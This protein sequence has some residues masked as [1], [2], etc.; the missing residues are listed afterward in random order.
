MRLHEKRTLTFGDLADVDL[1]VISIFISKLVEPP[2]QIAIV[3]AHERGA[4]IHWGCLVIL[5]SSSSPPGS[6]EPSVGS[7]KHGSIDPSLSI[8][9][10]L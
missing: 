8:W 4:V 2:K 6:Y 1:R 5:G 7:G 3:P 9:T 10:R